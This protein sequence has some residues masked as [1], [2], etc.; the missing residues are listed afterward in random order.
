MYQILIKKKSSSD[1]FMP[2][3]EE[4]E[5]FETDDLEVLREKF[6]KL[7]KIYPLGEMKAIH[8]LTTTLTVDIEE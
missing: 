5:V 7:M 4:G 6:E 3:E 2:Y 1:W 8:N